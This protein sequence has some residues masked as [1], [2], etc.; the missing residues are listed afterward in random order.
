V[1]AAPAAN[2]VAASSL[3]VWMHALG[4]D[5][6]HNGRAMLGR[7]ACDAGPFYAELESKELREK[8]VA[9]QSELKVAKGTLT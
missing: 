6:D 8:L 2:L 3:I 7:I 4:T 5:L 1:L 9:L